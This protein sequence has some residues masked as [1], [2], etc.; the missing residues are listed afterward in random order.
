MMVESLEWEPGRPHPLP[1]ISAEPARIVP[2][3][4]GFLIIGKRLC[5]KQFWGRDKSQIALF[6][7]LTA[8][9]QVIPFLRFIPRGTLPG[10]PCAIHRTHGAFTAPLESST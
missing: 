9:A 5:H 1:C 3:M 10:G 4:Y 8:M 2:T 6:Q 7:P